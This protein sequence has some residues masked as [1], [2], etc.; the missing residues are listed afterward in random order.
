MKPSRPLTVVNTS[1]SQA[2]PTARYVMVNAI[3]Q[4]ASR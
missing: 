2:A 1:V 3:G 4:L